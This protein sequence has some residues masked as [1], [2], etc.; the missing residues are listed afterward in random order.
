ME[1]L[2]DM[3]FGSWY[4]VQDGAGIYAIINTLNNKMYIG[5]TQTLR[6]R[7]RQ[8]YTL[9]LRNQHHSKK[10]QNAVNKYGIN[11]FKFTVLERCEP[12]TDTLLLLEQKYI[13]E[14]GYYNICKI[15]GKTTGIRGKGHILSESQR[16]NIIAANKRRIYTEQ[17]R[18]EISE[19][20]NKY[21]SIQDKKNP[22]ECYS[23]DGKLI[24][25]YESVMEASRAIKKLLNINNARVGIKRAYQG[26]QHTAYGFKWK[27]KNKEN[28]KQ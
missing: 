6:K 3:M 17:M 9:L 14:L 22:I 19:R 10:L 1:K 24:A 12:I 27:L 26:K 7:F 23:I 15:A 2:Y 21:K 13:D 20:V 8:H 4:N 5:S 11:V 16:Q 28:D 18:K 25:T